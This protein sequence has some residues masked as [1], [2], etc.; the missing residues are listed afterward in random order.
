MKIILNVLQFV[1]VAS[2]LIFIFYLLMALGSSHKIPLQTYLKIVIA[3]LIPTFLY[4]YIS[5][6][7]RKD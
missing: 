5:Y 2:S 4:F 1:C 6:L 7:K 3:I